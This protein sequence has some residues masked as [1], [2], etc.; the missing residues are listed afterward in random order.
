MKIIID[1][2]IWISFVIGKRL[3]SLRKILTN[4]QIQIFVC[5]ELIF[6]FLDVVSRPK[7]QKIVNKSDITATKK[8][9]DAYCEFVEIEHNAKS[10]I[11]DPKDLFLFSLAESINA[12]YIVTG[13]KDLLILGSHK[14]TK[15]LSFNDFR[16]LL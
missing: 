6:E 3:S 5:A 2:N 12:D 4:K 7:I 8:L 11:R 15:I 16:E 14:K 13:D 9:L 10:A 1:N